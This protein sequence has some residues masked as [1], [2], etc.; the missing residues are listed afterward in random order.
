MNDKQKFIKKLEKEGAFRG[1]NLNAG[2]IKKI[3][4]N[5]ELLEE[6]NNLIPEGST[7]SEKLFL[8]NKKK[9]TCEI[10][11]KET[12]F[13]SYGQGYERFC[14][15]K[16]RNKSSAEKKKATMLK[17]YGVEHPAQSKE[18]QA[19][20]RKTLKKNYGVENAFDLANKNYDR[21][22][23]KR[24]ITMKNRYGVEYPLQSNN[25]KQRAKETNLKK[26]GSTCSVQGKSVKEKIKK[27]NLKKY[28]VEYSFQRKDVKKKISSSKRRSMYV[29][30]VGSGRL[31]KRVT[32]LF[33]LE[34]YTGRLKK[35]PF[36]CNRCDKEFRDDL[37]DGK[38][39]RCPHC[40]PKNGAVRNPKEDEVVDFIRTLI[41]DVN[42]VLNDREILYGKELDI[43]LPDYNLAIEYNELWWHSEKFKR[44]SK[45]HIAKTTGCEK[46]NIRLIHVFE[47]EWLNKRE[48][49]E[50]I[51][52]NAL[53]I[54]KNKIGARNLTYKPVSSKKDRERVNLF[55]EANHLQGNC[56]YSKAVCLVDDN[57]EIYSVLTFKKPRYSKD[58]DYEL[59]RYAT[60]M[61]TSVVG[62]FSKLLKHFRQENKGSI[63]TYSDRR[64]FTGDI[65]RSNNFEELSPT[66]PDYWYSKDYLVRENRLKY[67]KH[68]IPNA[69]KNLTEYENMQLL[70]Y[71]RIWGCG[72]W[73][74][75]L[76]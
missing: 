17:K 3:K 74:F 14:S 47:D 69:D 58:A 24:K 9:T 44:G 20:M 59:V 60:K 21:N 37:R 64:L 57:D 71:D 67:Q 33:P 39:P 22:Q 34:E 2:F 56:S 8:L 76:R 40:Y 19:K 18:I 32:P 10:C 50:S 16:C 65:Y 45:Y 36:K 11:G 35:Y 72:N 38:I 73:K 4:N 5:K 70:G 66:P 13:K 26:Y 6:L 7:I 27:N 54:V 31:Q 53:G 41:P 48:I 12:K 63:L 52:S 46:A 42:I 43:Y 28:G 75:I 23:N 68:K 51:I 1:S 49:V 55:V 29:R 15:K 61:N 25:I 62:G 30:L